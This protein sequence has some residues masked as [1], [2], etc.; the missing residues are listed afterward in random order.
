MDRPGSRPGRR[1]QISAGGR[2]VG[3][4]PRARR[5][6]SVPQ[7]TSTRQGRRRPSDRGTR[8]PRPGPA[9]RLRRLRRLGP[10]RGRRQADLLRA[11]RPAAPRPGVGRHRGQ[12]RPPDPGLQGHGPG[13]AGLRRDDARLAQGPPRDRPR[14]LLH[15]RRQHLAERP[16][17]VPAHRRRLDRARPQRQPDQHRTSCAEMVA[18]L[19]GPAGELDLTRGR[20]RRRPT[21]PAWSPRCSPTT[22]T[23][24]ARAAR[25]RGAA[26]ARAAP[27]AS[28]G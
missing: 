6:G 12:Q 13:L 28:S 11:L 7:P 25:A 21:T 17:D 19:P 10:R 23:R 9:G 14:A 20:R 8:P 18:D 16:A 22:P 27:S 24:I 5:L 3:D 4:R 2:R 15:D 26:A 1:P